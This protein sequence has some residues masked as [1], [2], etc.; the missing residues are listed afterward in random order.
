ML[1]EG[2]IPTN[3]GH[4]KSPISLSHSGVGRRHMSV[5]W[6]TRHKSVTEVPC[7]TFA[8][9]PAQHGT[10]ARTSASLIWVWLQPLQDMHTNYRKG[11]VMLPLGNEM[12]WNCR[13]KEKQTR[14]EK[15][16]KYKQSQDIIKVHCKQEASGGKSHC[17]I[18]QMILSYPP[19][20]LNCWL[21]FIFLLWGTDV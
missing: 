10:S 13:K 14:Y 17:F 16:D 4:H 15:D 1:F 18:W 3:L 2:T 6:Q 8:K 19:I 9:N 11:S 21:I 12:F 5:H 7:S 20:I